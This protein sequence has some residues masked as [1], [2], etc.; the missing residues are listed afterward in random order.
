VILTKRKKKRL[1]KDHIYRKPMASGLLIVGNATLIKRKQ[2]GN[3]MNHKKYRLMKL[4]LITI[5]SVFVIY[6]LV[7]MLGWYLFI[8]PVFQLK[9]I[10]YLETI[11]LIL[12]FFTFFYKKETK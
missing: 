8:V 3:K 1:R 5:V 7:I 10:N 12:L 9:Q 2:K 6:P 11:G 4:V